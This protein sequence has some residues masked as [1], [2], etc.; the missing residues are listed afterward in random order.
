MEL[1]NLKSQIY[2]LCL[3]FI[4]VPQS[5]QLKKN[6]AKT[7]ENKRKP[8]NSYF[9]QEKQTKENMNNK[10]ATYVFSAPS[11]FEEQILFN[12]THYI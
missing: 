5:G 6:M 10:H 1:F 9:P 3:R 8:F 11:V 4:A 2:H 12:I 7:K